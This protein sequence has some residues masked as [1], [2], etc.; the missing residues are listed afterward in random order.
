MTGTPRPDDPALPVFR[1]WSNLVLRFALFLTEPRDALP[2]SAEAAR[3]AQPN[4]R[5]RTP[6]PD[7]IDLALPWIRHLLGTLLN[8]PDASPRRPR[9]W[10][11]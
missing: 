9:H 10:H 8:P 3:I 2:R 4:R 11:D 5:A 7:P 1:L 6:T